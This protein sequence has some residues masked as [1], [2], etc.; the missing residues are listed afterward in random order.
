MS[1]QGNKDEMPEE[2]ITYVY[3]PDDG[4]YGTIVSQGAWASIIKYYEDGIEYI[5]ELTNDEFIIVDEIG[6]GYE[7]EDF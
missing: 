5:I 6:I 7:G 2:T 3:V 1:K 4:A